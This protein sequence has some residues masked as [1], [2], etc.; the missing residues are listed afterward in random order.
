M[1]KFHF[2]LETVLKVRKSKEEDALRN[3]ALT[4][5][6]LQ[7]RISE[8]LK[9]TLD[10][11][12]ALERREKLGNEPVVN[13]VFI[14]ENDFISGTKQRI[15]QAEQAIWRANKFVEKAMRQYLHCRRQSKT[16]ETLKE[17]AYQEY[18]DAAN[19]YEQKQLDNLYLMRARLTRE[20]A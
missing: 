5:Q 9:L 4:Q 3:L 18:K 19:K 14:I 17:K 2:K 7:T 8:K 13:S 11:K 12:N 16:I 6:H 15:I 20:V 10:L 1:R